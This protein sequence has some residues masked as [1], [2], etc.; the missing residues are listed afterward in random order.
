MKNEKL[1]VIVHENNEVTVRDGRN[2]TVSCKD[3]RFSGWLTKYDYEKHRCPTHCLYYSGGADPVD[4]DRI[5]LDKI[6]SYFPNRS[7]RE[8]IF[9]KEKVY[10]KCDEKNENGNCELYVKA[11]PISIW[12]PLR[13]IGRSYRTLKMR[14]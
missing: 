1:P 8:S 10:P 11:K 7:E 4:K 9:E 14:E 6:E 13:W 2:L 5:M 12:N 3:C